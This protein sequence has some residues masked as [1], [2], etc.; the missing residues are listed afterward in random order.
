MNSVFDDPSYQRSTVF[1]KRVKMMQAWSDYCDQ[2]PAD[3][4]NVIGIRKE[5]QS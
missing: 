2:L 4:D 3:V 5:A 1:P